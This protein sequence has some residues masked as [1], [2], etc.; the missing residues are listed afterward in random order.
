MQIRKTDF[1]RNIFDDVYGCRDKKDFEVTREM[2][3]GL[4][5]ALSTISEQEEKIIYLRYKEK[6][7]IPSR[8][9]KS[10]R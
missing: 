9:E 1:P 6:M 3:A 10:I 5:V 2:Y 8:K 4:M 7:V